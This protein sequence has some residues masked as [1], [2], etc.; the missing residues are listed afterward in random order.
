M[1]RTPTRAMEEAEDRILT[2]KREV[3]N[4][5]RGGGLLLF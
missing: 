4:S 3:D 5:L 1:V 2:T